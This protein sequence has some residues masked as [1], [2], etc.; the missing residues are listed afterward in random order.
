M[1]KLFLLF[2]LLPIWA[3][4]QTSG[5]PDN[6]GYVWRNSLDAQGPTYN[7]IDIT[8]T[9]TQVSGLTDDNATAMIPMGMN[10][11]Y[12]WSDFNSLVIGSNGWISFDNISNIAHCFP[13]L[14]TPGGAG[15]N[16]IAPFMSDLRIDG[17]GNTAEV[18]YEHDIANQRFIVSFI[19]VPWWSPNAPG[20]VG[21]NSF[22]LIL[23]NQDSSI[24]FQYQQS[25]AASFVDNAGCAT[26]VSIGIENIT[27]NIGL[28]LFQDALPASA[29]AYKFYYPSTVLLSVP[30]VTPAWAMNSTSAGSFYATGSTFDVNVNL[31]S[32]GNAD[33]TSS[34]TGTHN[35]MAP[36]ASLAWTDTET[37]TGLPQG[38][39][40]T[41]TF[42]N[43]STPTTAGQYTLISSV[44]SAQDIN[45]SNDGLSTE[46]NFLD[47]S[48][49]AVTLS[50]VDGH[51][52]DGSISWSGGGGMAVYFEPPT[53]PI[54]VDSLAFNLNIT[55]QGSYYIQIYDDNG[56]NGNPGTLLHSD[57]VM[58]NPVGSNGWERWML[59]APLTIN[60]GGFYVAWVDYNGNILATT[61]TS[62]IARRAYE[63]ITG[64]WAQFRY[65]SEQDPFIE[66]V[67]SLPCQAVTANPTTT[68]A[69]CFGSSDGTVSTA[70]SGGTAPYTIDW[71]GVNTSALAA[72][73]YSYTIT[74]GGGCSNTG[75]ISINQPTGI[76]TSLNSTDASCAG[77][78]DG[79][80][81]L[82]VFGGTSPYVIDWGG[83]D[84][85]ALAAGTYGYT[86]TDANGCINTNTVTINEP[87]PISADSLNV[88]DEVAGS[89]GSID[90]VVSGGT[91]P[92]TYS[93][94]NGSTTEDISG[95]VAGTYSVTITD[96]NGC[97]TTASATV[98]SQGSSLSRLDLEAAVEL[99]P[100]PSDG[101]IQLQ[102]ADEL[103][104]KQLQLFDLLGQ[105]IPI[106]YQLKEQTQQLDLQ[107]LP[108]AFY[109]LRVTTDKGQL[110]KR[111]ILR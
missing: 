11:H 15:D 52:S 28:S 81:V 59:S 56:V 40:H 27:G 96:A 44:S 71:G 58:S 66:A 89:D 18:W 75:S 25:D 109:W 20:Y 92:Y 43:V 78:S 31:S 84:S 7:W 19:N 38:S 30:D 4:A 42:T 98:I 76:G 17:A 33:I 103:E 110:S 100:N 74:D 13:A 54:I 34:I 93:W 35:L 49:P 83:A 99:F 70:P 9:G 62:P 73:T 32:V 85:S 94:S 55:T 26:D 68:D 21:N 107:E 82:T 47:L 60:S 50:Y 91:S 101:L 39:N 48:Q 77:A 46:I 53:Y 72:G 64:S 79:T 41:S 16:V 1:K 2:M 63:F 102:L 80:A 8:A 45:P 97:N 22:Q 105:E 87:S 111:I 5:G 24:T 29:T 6:Y 23:S 69:N 106:S 12:Y 67:F 10:F 37:I 95:L 3:M 90:L 36:N 57:T 108:A 61:T 14:P 104:L 51:T 86:I 88:T 65:N